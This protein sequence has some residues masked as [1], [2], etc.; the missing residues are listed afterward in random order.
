MTPTAAAPSAKELEVILRHLLQRQE[1][2]QGRFARRLHDELGQVLAMLKLQLSALSRQTPLPGLQECLDLTQRAVNHT[3]QLALDARPSLLDDLGIVPALRWLVQARLAETG[4]T[5]SVVAEPEAPVVPAAWSSACYR[6]AE[7][8]VDNALCHARARALTVEI[9]QRGPG[10][11]LVI[12]DDGVGF[13][14]ADH[15]ADAGLLLMR[16]RVRLAGGE[17]AVQSQPGAGTEVRVR[18][19]RGT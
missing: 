4:L 11:D 1:K 15:A 13:C 19:D 17:W 6:V 18:F 5:G 8:A 10:L 16:E 9:R 2:E 14:L 12:R 7:D 3:R